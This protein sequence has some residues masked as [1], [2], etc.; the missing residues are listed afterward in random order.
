M[1]KLTNSVLHN[2]EVKGRYYTMRAQTHTQEK[3]GYLLPHLKSKYQLTVH[4][5]V[6]MKASTVTHLCVTS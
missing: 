6:N 5:F 2:K 4:Y 1:I 3:L